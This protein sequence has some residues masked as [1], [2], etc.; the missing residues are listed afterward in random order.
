MSVRGSFHGRVEGRRLSPERDDGLGLGRSERAS[1]GS[2]RSDPVD[3]LAGRLVGAHHDAGGRDLAVDE[4]QPGGDRAVREQALARPEHERGRPTGGTRR[5]GRA[6]SSVWIRFPLPCTCSSGPVRLLERRDAVGGVTL[7]SGPTAPTRS[8]GRPRE[9]TNF[10]ASFS[11]LP[12]ASSGAL[13]QYAREDLVGP[14]PEQHVER[15]A[16]RL[17]HDLAHQ[18]VPVVHRPAAVFEAAAVV[19]LRTAREPA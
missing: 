2:T 9:A 1:L 19:L 16:Q 11:G 17:G 3:D 5:R 10:V 14:A 18:V 6:R 8:A 7:R 4:L 15:H 13:G 12:P